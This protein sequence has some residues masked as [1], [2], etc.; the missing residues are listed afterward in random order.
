MTKSCSHLKDFT[1]VIPTYNGAKRLPLVLERLLQQE[2]L[3]Q[4]NWEIILV[5]NNSCDRTPEVFQDYQNKC[6]TNCQLRYFFEKAQGA[7]FAR[8]RGVSES[9]SDLIAFIDDDNIPE[10]DWVWQSYVFGQQHPAAGA[11]SGQIHGDFEVNPPENFEKIQGFLAIREHGNQPFI[12]KA[13]RLILPP[14]AA[15]VVRKQAWCDSV[16]QQLTLTGRKGKSLVA[17]E[18]TEAL[19][20]LHKA[21]WEIWYNPA[22]HVNHKIPY[23]RIE[24]KY[25]LSLANGCGLCSFQL[26]LVN[27]KIWQ[28]P[29]IL[30]R[31]FLGNLYRIVYYFIKYRGNF[32][33]N[34]IAH[35]QLSFFL[36]SIMSP[37][38]A[39]SIHLEAT[40]NELF[41]SN[42]EPS[43]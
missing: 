29:I 19:L 17:G 34:L 32:K 5:D 37:F 33:D 11:W 18:D 31:I 9:L 4:I 20:Y 3:E 13:S 1:V 42:R 8:N 14:G 12:F 16:P 10:L 21:G 35:F 41:S 27:A 7:S 28:T 36:G 23:W 40:V 15:L 24:K 6:K 22:M 43:T 30:T 25:L 39:L 2:K 38:Y 26:R